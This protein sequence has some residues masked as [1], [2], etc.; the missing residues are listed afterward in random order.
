MTSVDLCFWLWPSSGCDSVTD[1]GI[2]NMCTHLR[3]VG[4]A[5][6]VLLAAVTWG[7]DAAVAG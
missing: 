5:S 2:V 4:A 3:G 6:D 1:S 7:R